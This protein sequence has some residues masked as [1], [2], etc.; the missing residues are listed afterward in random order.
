MSMISLH[1]DPYQ[2]EPTIR[3][4]SPSGVAD[5]SVN[6]EGSERVN[7]GFISAP[8]LFFGK[9]LAMNV[10]ERG[11][12][13]V[14]ANQNVRVEFHD[15][16]H[17]FFGPVLAEYLYP[18]EQHEE[19]LQKGAPLT[20]QH[21]AKIIEKGINMLSSLAEYCRICLDS[22][23]EKLSQADLLDQAMIHYAKKQ[24]ELALKEQSGVMNML[25]YAAGAFVG[26]AQAA[27]AVYTMQHLTPTDIFFLVDLLANK[28]LSKSMETFI[29]AKLVQHI[30]QHLEAY[31]EEQRIASHPLNN[32]E[33]NRLRE[34]ILGQAHSFSHDAAYPSAKSGAIH[35]AALAMGMAPVDNLLDAVKVIFQGE[36]FTT[37]AHNQIFRDGV[38]SLI[39][40]IK[41]IEDSI[42]KTKAS[43]EELSRIQKAIQVAGKRAELVLEKTTQAPANS[44][45][46][47]R[48]GAG[49]Q[50]ASVKV[51]PLPP[52]WRRGM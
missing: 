46:Q 48:V 1:S 34:Q 36:T 6:I 50:G 4:S 8:K 12:N 24:E 18:Q 7:S 10:Q 39:E 29:T 41:K 51:N 22:N 21:V 20:P 35:T 5:F 23:S 42:S 43:A 2:G 13:E 27:F 14:E 17:A 47:E 15:S 38:T 28:K 32:Q 31:F 44:N 30:E 45:N 37:G 40:N 33:R 52:P 49:N 16:L 26:G 9:Y 3:S 25:P 19:F 11:E